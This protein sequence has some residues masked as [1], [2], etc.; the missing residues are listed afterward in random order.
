[1]LGW[2]VLVFDLGLIAVHRQVGVVIAVSTLNI[3]L[4][5]LRVLVFDLGLI[6]VH[7]QV[8][9]VIAVSTLNILLWPS[10]QKKFRAA[11]GRIP[12]GRRRDSR[13]VA[14]QIAP[15]ALWAVTCA[16]R[17]SKGRVAARVMCVKCVSPCLLMLPLECC[18]S[19][20]ALF[21]CFT[22]F[23]NELH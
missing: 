15:E 9:V 7:R 22:L 18:N 2:C 1:M 14:G 10:Q 21:A 16:Q 3:L 12:P 17:F 4:W 19:R 23:F 8:G 11:I 20:V 13:S 5:P 6:A